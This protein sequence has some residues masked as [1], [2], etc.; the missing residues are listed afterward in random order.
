MPDKREVLKALACKAN[1]P[2]VDCTG[3]PYQ[4]RDSC[5][6]QQICEDALILLI[7]KEA[8]H[9]LL[10]RVRTGGVK[11]FHGGGIVVF[12]SAW[13][14]TH[15]YGESPERH[16]RWITTELGLWEWKVECSACGNRDHLSGDPEY[17]NTRKYCPE[18][19]AKMDGE[20]EN[21]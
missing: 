7:E 14:M 1:D 6:Y 20:A 18:C 2:V 8:D 11:K 4:D 3:C 15:K 17:W 21:A 12:N 5:D 10:T 9:E 16:G 13:Y 19:G